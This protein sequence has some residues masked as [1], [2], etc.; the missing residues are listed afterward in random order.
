MPGHAC[1]LG[2]R[3]NSSRVD[4]THEEHSYFT[5]NDGGS[6]HRRV[7]RHTGA[8]LLLLIE[9]AVVD[10]PGLHFRHEEGAPQMRRSLLN[11][12]SSRHWRTSAPCMSKLRARSFSFS[13]VAASSGQHN[14]RSSSSLGPTRVAQCA[15]QAHRACCRSGTGAPHRVQHRRLFAKQQGQQKS[16]ALDAFAECGRL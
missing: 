4:S 10:Q 7:R 13:L 16:A 8:S 5:S 12:A 15:G 14:W 3:L 6:S 1:W 2:S 11:R 9:S